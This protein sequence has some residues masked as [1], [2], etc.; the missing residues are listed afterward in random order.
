MH[1]TP[2]LP[3]AAYK[4]ADRDVID[5]HRLLEQ[6]VE[7]EAAVAGAAAVEAEGEL[8]QVVVEVLRAAPW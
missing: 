5:L 7:D 6:S 2:L 3:A 1:I 4:L 8:V